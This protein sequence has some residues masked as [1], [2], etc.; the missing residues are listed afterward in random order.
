MYEVAAVAAKLHNVGIVGGERVKEMDHYVASV[1]TPTVRVTG[2]GPKDVIPNR[3]GGGG[4]PG[5]NVSDITC[6]VAQMAADNATP[7]ALTAAAGLP[8]GEAKTFE[9]HVQE[10]YQ[11]KPPATALAPFIVAHAALLHKLVRLI[12]GRI[13]RLP[14]QT[15]TKLVYMTTIR[16]D[17]AVVGKG[18][19]GALFFNVMAFQQAGCCDAWSTRGLSERDAK[20]R[21]KQRQKAE[22][23]RARQEQKAA[24]EAERR[25]K[26]QGQPPPDGAEQHHHPAA[27]AV[28]TPNRVIPGQFYRVLRYW[29]QRA[30]IAADLPP[31]TGLYDA[32]VWERF[33][34]VFEEAVAAGDAEPLD[35]ED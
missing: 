9:L 24:K 1:E 31:P 10:S 28:E 8:T 2:G 3:T 26:K 13:L 15:A 11:P 25:R 20:K 14:Q 27:A 7:F 32:G 4:R 22:A 12:C 35:E 19:D 34:A 29:T 23:A 21:Q 6:L 18:G 5:E 30:A 33:H 17:T 16:A